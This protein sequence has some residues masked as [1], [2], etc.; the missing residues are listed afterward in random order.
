MSKVWLTLGSRT[1]K[2]QNRTASNVVTR[3]IVNRSVVKD[4]ELAADV[5]VCCL[6]DC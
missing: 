6:G 1:A 3:L 5:D 2:E 4:I